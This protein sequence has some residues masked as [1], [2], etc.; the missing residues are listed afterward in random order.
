MQEHKRE[1]LGPIRLA[2]QQ[3]IFEAETGAGKLFDILLIISILCSV[4]AVMLD[5]VAPIRERYGPA[6]HNA[7]WFFTILFTIEYILRLICVGRPAKYAFSFFGLVDLVSIV[8]TYL[9]LLLPGSQ[10]LLVI[11]IL[12]VLRVFRVLKFVQYLEESR[13]L[14]QALRA[15]RKKITVFLF[16]V[17][18]LVVIL[19][20]VMYLIEGEANGFT[21]IP[22]SVYWAIVTL[23]TVGYGDI[24]PNTFPGQVLASFIM[25]LGYGI[26]AVPTGMVTAEIALAVRGGKG[27]DPCVPRVR[28]RGARLTTPNT[29]ITAGQAFRIKLE[30]L[31]VVGMIIKMNFFEILF[32]TITIKKRGVMKK[33]ILA[34]CAIFLFIISTS[35]YANS[36][37][38]A[39]KVSTLGLGG[40]GEVSLTD[41]IGIR[42]GFNY[43][44]YSFSATE[45]AI[46]YDFDLNLMS[47]PILWTTIRSKA[48]FRLTGG[49]IYNGNNFDA[50]ANYAASIDIG[51]T[52]YTLADIGD[53][54]AEIEFNAF[55]PYAGLGWD[56]T[57]GGER[58]FGFSFDCGRP[59]SGKP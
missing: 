22:R 17:L 31:S 57:F 7:E 56:T 43:F 45:G 37:S 23:T 12:R 36:A 39:A 54:T 18:T 15:S 47:V 8:P 46:D 58:R 4:A 5:S 20:S 25:L 51:G 42:A 16:A 41:S 32:F 50:S 26:I 44:T 38:V 2:L 30:I 19:G 29:V 9:S 10:F 21:S 27:L 48:A 52:I 35:A 49:V 6:L 3:T 13:L 33:K 24:S 28:R 1:G 34:L 55:A 59:V 40:E 11:R 14:L 53:M